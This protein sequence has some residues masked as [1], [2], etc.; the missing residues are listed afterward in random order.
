M[1]YKMNEINKNLCLKI[2]VPT[3][4]VDH[5]LKTKKEY[6]NLKKQEI[7]YMFIKRN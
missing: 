5:F 3:V 6:K 7:Q 2:C 4:L 1:K